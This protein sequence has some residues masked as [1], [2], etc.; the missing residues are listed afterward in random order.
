MWPRWR[1]TYNRF[2]EAGVGQALAEFPL[3]GQRRHSIGKPPGSAVQRLSAV[4]AVQRAIENIRT[5]ISGRRTERYSF[6]PPVRVWRS[7]RT[8]T[9]G[10]FSV[11]HG[12]GL[13]TDAKDT[14]DRGEYGR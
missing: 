5:P 13:E 8:G 12:M 3:L 6:T 1:M 2:V 10:D 4:R 11:M 9:S 14:S 7:A